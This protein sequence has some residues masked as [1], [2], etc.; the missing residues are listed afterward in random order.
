MYGVSKD[1]LTSDSAQ[2]EFVKSPNVSGKMRPE[3]L[4]IH[5]T[6]SGPAADIASY[7]SRPAAKVSAHYCVD[8]N[9]IVQCVRDQ[10]VGWH[11]PG[12]MSSWPTI[13]S[14]P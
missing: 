1:R 4:V 13:S 3:F 2:V 5:Y 12:A 6:A 7:F 8:A 9:S 14:M 11:A 10:D